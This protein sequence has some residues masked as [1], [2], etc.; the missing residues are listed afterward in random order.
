MIKRLAF[1][2]YPVTDIKKSRGF[3]EQVLGLKCTETF[4]DGWFEYDIGGTCFAI[5]TFVMPQY[6]PGKQGSIAFEVTDLDE[7]IRKVESQGYKQVIDRMES[8]VCRGAFFHD[9][10][11]NL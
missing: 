7:M 1:T 11:G 10:D 3:Y 4:G 2:V 6:Q 9:P 8:P 5:T